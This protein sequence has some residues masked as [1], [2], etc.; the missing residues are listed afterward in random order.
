MRASK[1]L[2]HQSS[3]VLGALPFVF[4][5]EGV[6]VITVKLG[7]VQSLACVGRLNRC[8]RR[9]SGPID[10]AVRFLDRWIVRDRLARDIFSFLSA[11]SCSITKRALNL[12]Y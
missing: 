3:L 8:H 5:F 12:S 7:Q 2:N 1:E 6:I 10:V 4:F 9:D 11:A